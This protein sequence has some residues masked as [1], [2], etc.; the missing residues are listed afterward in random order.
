MLREFPMRRRRRWLKV[1]LVFVGCLLALMAGVW[2]WSLPASGD[3]FSKPPAIVPE[4]PGVLLR[5]EPYTRDMPAGAR[6]WR[7]LYTTRD[8]N[9]RPVLASALVVAPASGSSPH[10][11]VAWTHGTTGAVPGCGP[12]PLGLPFAN[13]P[14]F[15]AAI[16]Q[17]WAMVATD[18]AGMAA[19]G[20]APYLVGLG[21][22]RSALDS[23]RAARQLQDVRL[24]GETVVWGHSQGGHAALWTA[25][26]WPRYAPELRLL[27][28]AAAAPATDLPQ[29]LSR[30][31]GEPVGRI[32]GAF[33][34]RAYADTYPDVDFAAETRA[35]TRPLA[36][37]MAARCLA[38]KQALVSVLEAL[39]VGGS[40]FEGPPTDG[41]FGARLREN[42][43]P[44]VAG[45]PVWIAQGDRDTLV[46]PDI[47][48]GYVQQWCA[49]GRALDYREYAGDDHLSL[50]A[51]DSPY[52]RD[53]L[54]WSRDRFAGRP[55]ASNCPA[56]DGSR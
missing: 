11:V 52:S 55:A 42:I 50:V 35:A 25:A 21:E 37:D 22:A 12:V 9:D 1:L 16:E 44:P 17:G 36:R 43:P 32:M 4:Q 33:V 38:G 23:L 53:L 5:S 34:L 46:L 13:V 39:V 3:P 47:Q 28:V 24:A 18:Y 26:E 48:R 10:P 15:P 51:V 2:W 19:Q 40:I 8:A 29:L 7:I 6:G 49:Q 56:R 27:G 54:A 31:A 30:I 45:P 20:I 41:R 14:A